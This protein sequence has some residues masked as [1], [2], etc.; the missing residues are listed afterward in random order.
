VKV[1]PIRSEKD[2]DNAIA[3]I[4]DL[5]ASRDERFHD[6]IEVLQALIERWE[7]ANYRFPA[8]TPIEAIR[9]RM[10]Q[11]GLAP[12][13]LEPYIGSRSRVSEV[14]SG[15]RPLSIDMIRA[16]HRHL[17]IPAESLIAAASP[18]VE[19]RR[20]EPSKAA[21]D[22]LRTVGLLRPKETVSA[23]IARAFE[24]RSQPAL[25]RKTRT[26]RTNTKT[27]YAALDAWCAVVQLRAAKV[28]LTGAVAFPKAKEGAAL[29]RLSALPDGLDRVSDALLRLGIIFVV[30]EHL[31]GTYLDGAAMC[32]PSDS[33]PIIAVTLRHDRLDNFWFTLLHEFCHVAKHLNAD[34]PLILD[35]LDV[36]TSNDIEDEADRFAQDT[37]IHPAIWDRHASRDL[38]SEALL[39]IADEAQIDP[40]IVAGRWQREFKDYRRFSKLVGRGQVRDRLLPS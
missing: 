25:L 32:R 37:L 23:F 27:D 10:A 4:S 34:R 17:A 22:K 29:A 35:D 28:K 36:T 12:R 20:A 6:E 16:L 13:D 26:D 21:M 33:A 15:V 8:P 1:A 40:A 19:K 14:L 9:F 2:W 30:A 3:R 7:R 38:S 18:E 5:I 24:A 31:P 39:Q 11:L